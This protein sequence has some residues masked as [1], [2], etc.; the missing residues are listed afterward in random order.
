MRRLVGTLYVLAVAAGL[1]VLA[2][3][4]LHP[5]APAWT[6]AAGLGTAPWP[7][8]GIALAALA[9]PLLLPPATGR[10]VWTLM[11]LE[12]ARLWRGRVFLWG[13]FLVAALPP[14][15]GWLR[16]TPADASAWSL[17]A[18]LTGAALWVA[19]L[20]VLVL[21]AT[22][23]ASEISQG[24]MKMALPFAFRRSDWV[25]GKA[26]A[27]AVASLM[28]VS[29]ALVSAGVTAH[30]T[31]GFGDVVKTLP[32]GFGQEATTEVFQSA[33]EMGGHVRDVCVLALLG[34]VATG[35]MGLGLS[36][37]FSS[38]LAPLCL[39]FLLFV[40]MRFGDALL[41][42][43]RDVMAWLY[44]SYPGWMRDVLGSLGRGF[45]DSWHAAHLD[46][47]VFWAVATA[48][49]SLLAALVV[50]EWRELR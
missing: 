37:C 6:R 41:G 39:A 34:G 21:G 31:M 43:S 29:V 22:S 20:L 1:G 23:I 28:L 4:R 46:Q 15:V 27:L 12:M 16:A 35:W 13:L 38:T 5:A 8:L 42:L 11:R 18:H 49:L 14:L 25:L 19:S 48:T 17:W 33:R 50:F 44:P 36:A 10:R 3:G 40:A 7:L 9:L 26:L 47:G 30:A 45:N 2:V 32:A 24:T